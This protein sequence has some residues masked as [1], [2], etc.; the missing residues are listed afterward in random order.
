MLQLSLEEDAD[1]RLKSRGMGRV[2]HRILY[3][4]HFSPGITVGEL[5]IV[6]DVR[7]QN[8]QRSLR[9]LVEAGFVLARQNPNDGRIRQLYSSRKG[10]KL[11]EFVSAAQRER[12]GRA[13]D[14]ATSAHVKS[15]LKVMA[16]ML[17]PDRRG[18]VERL[19]TIDDPTEAV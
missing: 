10:D 4:A 7:H 3:F 19:T 15:Y 16:A 5:L 11:L 8:I 14:H 13:L 9:Q 18:W 12:I 6:L 1:T 17:G 2:Q